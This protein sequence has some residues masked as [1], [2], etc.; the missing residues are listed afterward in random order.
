MTMHELEIRLECDPWDLWDGVCNYLPLSA[1]FEECAEL[2]AQTYGVAL[3][4]VKEYFV[5]EDDNDYLV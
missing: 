3:E 5:K 1:T 2:F 4:E